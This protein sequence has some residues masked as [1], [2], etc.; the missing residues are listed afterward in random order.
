MPLKQAIL[1]RDAAIVDFPTAGFVPG[2]RDSKSW[3][4]LALLYR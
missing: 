3:S 1:D 4:P 2:R